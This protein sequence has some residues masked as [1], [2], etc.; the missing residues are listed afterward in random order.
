VAAVQRPA[1][2]VFGPLAPPGAAMSQ[3]TRSGPAGGWPTE[4]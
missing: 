1:A 4:W 3:P 2:D